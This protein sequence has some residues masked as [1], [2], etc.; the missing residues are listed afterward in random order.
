MDSTAPITPLVWRFDHCRFEEASLELWVAEEPADLERK[1][2]E[3]L[4][5]LLRHAGEVVTKDELQAAVWPGRVLSDTVLTKAISRLR[6][7]LQDNDQRIVKTVHGYGYRLVAAVSV[8]AVST[9]PTPPPPAP[10]L[11]LKVGDQPPLRPQWRLVEHLDSGGFGEV[12][13][14]AQVKT[15]ETRVYK[16]ALNAESLAALK[17]EITLFRLLR[18]QLGEA[19]PIAEVRDWNLEEAPYFLEL[20][21]Y[22]AGN[23]ASWLAAR[24][25]TSQAERLRLFGDIAEAVAQVHGVGVLH[26][27]IKPSNL[28]IVEDDGRPKPLLADFGGGGVL[29]EDLITNAG[30]TRLGFS[31]VLDA[32][33]FGTPLY[34]A[35]ELL[36][37]QPH[38]VR[39]DV[40][41]LGV[42]LYQLLIGDFR[43]PL[44][45][46]WERRIDD[47]LLRE[48]ID[49]AV[50]G[51]PDRRLAN[52]QELADRVRSLD[53]RRAARASERADQKRR[54]EAEQ[55]LER[56]RMRRGWMVATMLALVIGLGIAWVQ[57]L[58]A[59]RERRR[60][61]ASAETAL[62]T[63]RFMFEG[64]L[65][66]LDAGQQGRS[67]ETTVKDLLD[68]AARAADQRL[69][70]QPEIEFHVRTALSNAYNQIDDGVPQARRQ[71]TLA[72]QALS[73]LADVDPKRAVQL[74][75]PSGLWVVSPSDKALFDHLLATARTEF[76]IHHPSILG[77]LGGLSDAEFRYGSLQA[78]RARARDA[79]ALSEQRKDAANVEDNIAFRIRLARE[80]ADFAEAESLL[81]AADLW[82][83][84]R[85]PPPPVS[86]AYLQM[87]RGIVR[88]SHGEPARAAADLEQGFEKL[89]ALQAAGT[90]YYRYP[91]AYL[92]MLRADQNR[93]GEAR[94]RVDEWCD[95]LQRT[96]P[97]A[98]DMPMEALVVAETAWRI[99]DRESALALLRG[100][101]AAQEVGRPKVFANHARLQLAAMALEDGRPDEARSWLQK[102]KP[103]DW[104][105]YRQGHPRFAVEAEVRGLLEQAEG[106]TTEA[107]ARLVE[108]RRLYAAAYA[109]GHWRL[110]RIDRLLT[111]LPSAGK[112]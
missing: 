9:S 4:R 15:G 55:A 77:L 59:D 111:A 61:E 74:I 5:H 71:E 105:D 104:Y 19:A 66:A 1:P 20:S 43:K 85:K 21:D 36:E 107:R 7:V 65:S 28:L 13:R 63:G 103:E 62:E 98:V 30:I 82:V 18:N 80:D 90:W 39:S 75:P 31:Q 76:G 83:H 64:L 54:I 24:G 41:A 50:Q 52:A 69:A 79:Q 106:R 112:T 58:K 27:D 16:F 37:G 11:G 91:L 84:A 2:L 94:R 73:R 51:S 26:K 48:D 68:N 14:V 81:P 70:N 8:T 42:L 110:K 22:P 109:P 101:D 35:P 6:E 60:A 99:G 46:G 38:T 92:T 53:S 89:S 44:A 33:H 34:A 96:S 3:V 10:V 45:S 72:H 86:L 17:R 56:L 87:D 67:R 40:Y 25:E 97:H 88:V 49:A 95:I 108:A 100:M 23:L 93:L 57:F 102:L 32:D 12:W 29:A 78:A 47:E